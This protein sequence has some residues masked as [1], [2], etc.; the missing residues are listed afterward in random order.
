MIEHPELGGDEDFLEFLDDSADSGEPAKEPWLV[1]VVD[2]ERAMFDSTVLALEGTTFDGKPIQLIYADSSQAGR[3]LL[4]TTPN[5]ACVLLDVVMETDHAGLDLAREIRNDLKNTS[6]RIILRTG[7]PGYAPPMDVLEQYDIN[8]YKEKTELTRTRLWMAI[9]CAIRSYQQIVAI[10]RSRAGL[11]ATIDACSDLM[12]K[13]GLDDFA[14]GVVTQIAAHL[15]IPPDGLLCVQAANSGDRPMVVGAAGRFALT[16]QHPVEDIGDE[17]VVAAIEA[18]LHQKADVIGATDMTLY[19]AGQTWTG[20]IFLR[21]R[22]SISDLDRELLSIFCQNVS[23]CFENLQL[24]ESVSDLAYRDRVTKLGTRAKMME[25]LAALLEAGKDPSVLI[26]DIDGFTTYSAALGRAFGEEILNAFSQKLTSV[27]PLPEKVGCLVKDTFCLVLEDEQPEDLV[28]KIRGN[29]TVKD[30]ELL[31]NVSFGHSGRFPGALAT[32]HS[33]IQQAEIAVKEAQAL[34]N[35]SLVSYSADIEERQRYRVLLAQELREGITRNQLRVVYQPQVDIQSGKPV[36]AEAL[37]RWVHPTRGFVS[38]VD[39][40][41]IAETSG[42][43]SDLGR[44]MVRNV[45]SELGDLLRSGRVQRVSINLSP[46]QLHEP[47]CLHELMQIADDGGL[48]PNQI[49]WEITESAIMTG[50]ATTNQLREAL[51]KGHPIAL[52]DFGTGY[53]SL[54][55]IQSMPITVVKIDRAFMKEAGDSPRSQAVLKSTVSICRANDLHTIAEGVE[56][57]AELEAV[58]AAG[59]ELVQGYFYSKPLPLA[60]FSEWLAERGL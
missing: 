41:S 18:A 4:E 25:V 49:E 52:D 6:I 51:E 58:R 31:L 33:L 34:G 60:G 19:I 42:V 7:Q 9:A 54:S 46:I 12:Q 20:A 39:F 53:S 5:I 15:D 50:D 45:C 14:R 26:A 28:Q 22:Q 59:I 43:I 17:S 47:A 37:V 3:R 13:R 40:I 55:M 30:Q 21:G 38:P 2:D 10:E 32:P 24:F 44:W 27:H 56:S 8:D 11:R 1:A 35:N 29:L 23:L 48:S 57:E 16:V 36:S